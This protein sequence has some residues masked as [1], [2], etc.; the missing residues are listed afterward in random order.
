MTHFLDEQIAPRV[1]QQIVV[2]A[3]YELA[4]AALEAV[5][6]RVTAL[7]NKVAACFHAN[8]SVFAP[9]LEAEFMINLVVSV[10]APTEYQVAALEAFNDEASELPIDCVVRFSRAPEPSNA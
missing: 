5:L 8:V 10:P 9:W 6:E 7:V 2:P 4:T 3:R 1:P